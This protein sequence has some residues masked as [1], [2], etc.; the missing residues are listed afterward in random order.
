MAIR[1][2]VLTVS[3]G[4]ARGDR[5]DISG[6][7][8]IETL[9][10]K[11]YEIACSRVIPDDSEVISSLLIEWS[12][13]IC[14][15]ILTTGGTGFSPRDITPEATNAVIERE[16]S[17]LTELLRWKG[18]QKLDRAVLSRGV[19]GIRNRTLIINLPGSPGGVRDGLE[20]LLPLLPHAVS[21]IKDEPVDHTPI[22]EKNRDATNTPKVAEDVP[23]ALNDAERGVT[24]P[25]PSTVVLIE[26]NIDDLSPEFY[27]VTMERL[28]AAGALDVFLMPIQMKKQRP[29]ILLSVISPSEKT[30]LL[31]D[32]IFSETGTF[33]IRYSTWNRFILNRSWETVETEYGTIRIK[34][35]KRH[36]E[37]VT[38]SP[39]YEDVKA[40]ACEKNIPVKQIY[41]AAQLAAAKIVTRDK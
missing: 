31:A 32:L 30:E 29:A 3:D 11:G 39:E 41:A 21:L 19:S 10:Q 25:T 37:I 38:A 20:I 14:D 13:S 1:V 9:E 33:G 16:A 6:K 27:E 15:L 4:C 12:S 34:I 36:G 35:G 28:F 23:T 40:A 24:D 2:G 7:I 22:I 8:L 17:G 26:T 5:E 18:Y